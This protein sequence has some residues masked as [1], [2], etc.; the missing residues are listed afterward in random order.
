MGVRVVSEASEN[1]DLSVGRTT[2]K[3]I[4][5]FKDDFRLMKV[6]ELALI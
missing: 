1:S 5:K 2:P 3:I 6:G 4:T